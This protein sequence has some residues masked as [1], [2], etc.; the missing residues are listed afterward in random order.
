MVWVQPSSD[1]KYS[2]VR[3]EDEGSEDWERV[4]EPMSG[5]MAVLMWQPGMTKSWSSRVCEV[6]RGAGLM[7]QGLYKG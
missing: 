5:D 7:A 2:R 3:T 1:S 6:C 4:V